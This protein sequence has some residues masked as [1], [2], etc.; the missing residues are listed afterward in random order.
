MSFFIAA[1]IF[2]IGIIAMSYFFSANETREDFLIGQR[3]FS[4]LPLAVSL[5]TTW[6]SAGMFIVLIYFVINDFTGY[7][8]LAL[9]AVTNL[10]VFSY[11][12]KKPYELAK[13]NGWITMTEMVNGIIGKKSAYFV[14]FLVALVFSSWLLFELVGSGLLLSQLTQLTY[15]QSV[16]LVSVIVFTYLCLGG[17][18]S[19]VRTDLIQ[20]SLLVFILITCIYLAKEAPA[21]DLKQLVKDKPSNSI[22][23]FMAGFFGYFALQFCEATVWQRVL[24][25]KSAK[26]AQRALLYT[27]FLYIISYGLVILMIILGVS[28]A[29]DLQNEALISFIAFEQLPNWLGALFL[30]TLL[31]LMMSTL[32]SVMFIAAQCFTTDIAHL[33]GKKME[34]PRNAMR[35]ALFGIIAVSLFVAFQTQ[36]ME[37]LFWFV[38]TLWASLTPVFYLFFPNNTPSDN[39]LFV[40]MIV[41]FLAIVGLYSTGHYQNHYVAYIFFTGLA[42]PPLLDKLFFQRESVPSKT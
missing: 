34:T 5:S 12:V 14:A 19:I 16:I 6:L 2:I 30:V 9:G 38:V 8:F 42:L 3:G 33:R 32:D 24:A 10:V 11:L 25:A 39:S 17:F 1:G 31:A 20:F 26:H 7:L 37:A 29:P 41:L 21:I 36:D 15:A 18:K 27:G 28:L 35:I 22:L 4:A 23:G 40:T 13:K